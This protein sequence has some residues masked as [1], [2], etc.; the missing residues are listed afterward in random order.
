LIIVVEIYLPRD[1]GFASP[2]IVFP[3]NFS[4]SISGLHWRARRKIGSHNEDVRP[5]FKDL[6]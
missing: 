4:A 2:T 6:G 1:T 3:T 5:W